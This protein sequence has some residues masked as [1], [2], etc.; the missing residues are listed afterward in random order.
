MLWSHYLPKAVMR[1]VL[2]GI[3]ISA[4]Q[5]TVGA[6][7]RLPQQRTV[8][9]REQQSSKARCCFP[10]IPKV[11]G[12]L[13][14]LISAVSTYGLII[15]DLI[16]S[17][18]FL[19]ESKGIRLRK[20]CHIPSVKGKP[21]SPD[22]HWENTHHCSPIESFENCNLPI[23]IYNLNGSRLHLDPHLNPPKLKYSP[24]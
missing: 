24:R 11:A 18:D 5:Q 14:S 17:I 3:F 7:E 1:K 10:N 23:L 8:H 16:F 13:S 12:H 2:R 22:M 20:K 9:S 15:T 6:Q 4:T 19:R 21:I